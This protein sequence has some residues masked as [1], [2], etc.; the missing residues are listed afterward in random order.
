VYLQDIT[1][2]SLTLV[3][4]G[5]NGNQ[6]RFTVNLMGATPDLSHLWFETAE[7]LVDEDD[8]SGCPRSD[9]WGEVQCV[10]VY[11]WSGGTTKLVSTGPKKTGPGGTGTTDWADFAG[12]SNGGARV[13]FETDEQLVDADTDAFDDTYMRAGGVTTLLSGQFLRAT[14]DGRVYL[15]TAD[16]LSPADTDDHVD[17]Y[18]WSGG[19]FELLTTGPLGGNGPHNAGPAGIPPDGG[20]YFFTTEEELTSDDVNPGQ[21]IYER[22]NGTTTLISKG[23]TGASAQHTYSSWGS[24]AADGGRSM[25]FTA[26]GRLVPEDQDNMPDLYVSIANQAPTCGSARAQPALLR[27]ANKRLRNVALTGVRDPDGD[28][29]D[30]EVTGITQDEPVNRG[31]DARLTSSPRLVQV[32]A[33]RHPRGD[34]RVYR[35]AFRAADDHGGE[36][37]GVAKVGVPRRKHRAAVD[38][39]PPSFDSLAP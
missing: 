13:Y 21:D 22:F 25:F 36:C 12:Y 7:P 39:A 17:D 2:N 3:S 6:D 8:D 27:P 38:S 16:R 26:Y 34:G 5:P 23:P 30:F 14:E 10:D 9:G 29:V 11:E 35:I 4:T 20:R 28:P 37:D 31:P 1:D 32:R 18:L 19:N 24:S 15:G 33:E